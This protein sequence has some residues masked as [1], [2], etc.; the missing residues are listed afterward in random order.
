MCVLQYSIN[1][2]RS[3]TASRPDPSSIC[4]R[5]A[6]SEKFRIP[7][8]LATTVLVN[9]KQ[10]GLKAPRCFHCAKTEISASL[11]GILI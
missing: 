7:Q 4:R 5:S 10:H 3:L 6:T 11:I 9:Q 2:N 1:T 8:G